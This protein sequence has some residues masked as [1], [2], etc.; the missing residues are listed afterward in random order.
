MTKQDQLST[1]ELTEVLDFAV[2]E[3]NQTVKALRQR[4]CDLTLHT[5]HENGEFTR[6]RIDVSMGEVTG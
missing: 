5:S 2:A 3:I 4:G 6:I 1:G